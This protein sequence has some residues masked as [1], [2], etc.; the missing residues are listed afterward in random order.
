VFGGFGLLA[1]ALAA[2]GI[3]GVMSYTVS[4]CTHE[5]GV[6]TALGA[7][8]SDVLGLVISQGIRLTLIG[9]AI[10]LSAAFAL[11]SLIKGRF[12]F[13]RPSRQAALAIH[14]HA[15]VIS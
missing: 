3:Y 13:S 10:G 4:M 15:G 7:Q 2:I 6:R 1:L 9:L 12:E 5:A 11:T 14:Y 8:P